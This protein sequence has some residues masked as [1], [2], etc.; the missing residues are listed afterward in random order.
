MNG[1]RRSFESFGLRQFEPSVKI[2]NIIGLDLFKYNDL[3]ARKV[4]KLY[5]TLRITMVQ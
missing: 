5:M 4:I 1:G 2:R 3:Y